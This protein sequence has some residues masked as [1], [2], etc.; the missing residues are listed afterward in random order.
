MQFL[1]PQLLWLL[2]LG[3]VPVLLYLFRRRA[4]TVGVSTLVFFKTL[5][6]EHQ[7]TAWL[8]RLKKLLSFVLTILVLVLTVLVLAG[9]AP[10]RD[11]AGEF[12][13]VILLIDRSASMALEDGA[14][15]SRLEAAKRLARDHLERVPEEVGTVLVAY[16][17]R[18]EVV[19]ARSLNR[20]ELVSRLEDLEVRP[21][22][23]RPDAARVAVEMIAGLEPPAAVWHYSDR[24]LAVAADPS[25]DGADPDPVEGAEGAAESP[26]APFPALPVGWREHLLA[27]DEVSNLAITAFELRAV[28]LEHSRYEVYAQVALNRA[29]PGPVEARLEVSVGGIPNQFRE[30]E[31]EPGERAGLNFRVNGA[32]RQILSLQLVAEGD[33]FAL[34]DRVT[35][36][37]PESRPIVAAWIRPDETEDPYTRLALSAIQ[38]SG[39]F[40]LLR[41]SPSAWPLSVPVDAVI[42]DSWLPEEWPEDLPAV[43]INPPGSSGPLM[44]RALPNPVPHPAVRAGNERHPVLFRVSSGRIALT[45]TAVFQSAGS[46]EP[47]WFAGNEPVLAA[48]EV[49]GQRLVVMA[50]SPGRSERLPLTSSFPLLM[51]NALFWVVNRGE[52]RSADVA[53]H[54]T[55]ELVEI[56][57]ES[58]TWRSWEGRSDSPR[59]RRIDLA[60]GERRVV[61]MDRIG[62]WESDAGARGAAHLLSAAESDLPS[63]A[64]TP[65]DPEAPGWSSG[66]ARLGGIKTWLLGLVVFVLLIESWLFHRHAVY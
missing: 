45:Q 4:R 9:L 35:V 42:F 16:D 56:P 5:A 54:R 40:E 33:R 19:L 37:L 17:A 25:G 55:G 47:L 61:E 38:E 20:R 18:A 23:A 1:H 26:A 60:A 62:T 29:A 65:T 59:T 31:L 24:P 6:Q 28:P 7:E 36:P 57:G 66:L 48:G 14:G 49:A 34:D 3:A 10:D 30:L 2:L 64:A 51:G 12:R 11:D 27:L 8:R 46:L 39:S 44:A 41:G 50:F 13:T 63:R 58:L 32:S 43:V 52:A 22:A 21:I 15:E 53:L